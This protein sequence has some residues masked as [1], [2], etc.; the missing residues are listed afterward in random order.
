M[1]A[2]GRATGYVGASGQW[3]TM[4]RP[5]S[6]AA[7]HPRQS[8]RGD[9]D[10]SVGHRMGRGRWAARHPTGAARHP[11]RGRRAHPAA[12]GHGP[13]GRQARLDDALGHT[14]W[15]VLSTA[16]AGG[17]AD[18]ERWRRASVQVLQLRHAGSDPGPGAVVDVQNQLRDW[19]RSRHV[20][21]MAVRPDSID[22]PTRRQANSLRRPPRPRCR[23]R[24]ESR[25]SPR[26]PLR[27]PPCPRS[28]SYS[29]I[30]G[31]SP[32]F[33]RPPSGAAGRGQRPT[34]RAGHARVRDRTRAVRPLATAG[35]PRLP[36]DQHPLLPGGPQE[37]AGE[38]PDS[39]KCRAVPLLLR[40][41][42]GGEQ[43]A[44]CIAADHGGYAS[45]GEPQPASVP[46]GVDVRCS[47]NDPGGTTPGPGV[48]RLWW[49]ARC[50]HSWWWA[51][52]G[53][54]GWGSCSG[55]VRRL[56]EPPRACSSTPGWLR[57]VAIAP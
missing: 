10:P 47:A 1:G 16:P 23:P 33:P 32:P 21:A 55:P 45:S 56:R 34:G 30:A 25:P 22:T 4:R 3:G 19:M 26:F 20:T 29:R 14:A 44:V 43:C 38:W 51:A 39:G 48:R 35:R 31:S 42:S 57:W 27:S 6:S 36:P 2:S 52:A 7:A 24:N 28:R 15:A 50:R 11:P 17:R 18:L 13:T 8:G 40:G 5:V 12:V 54:R 49:P 53:R 37:L 46:E 9:A 41:C